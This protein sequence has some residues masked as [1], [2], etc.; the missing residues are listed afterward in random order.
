MPSVNILKEIDVSEY[1]WCNSAVMFRVCNGIGTIT[2]K[3]NKEDENYCYYSHLFLNNKPILQ[4]YEAI[5]PTCSGMLATGYG[6]ENI[7]CPELKAVRECLNSNYTDIK[8]SAEMLKPLLALLD[9]GYYLLADIP[10]FPTDGNNNFFWSVPNDLTE[11]PA[12]CYSYY[13]E[14]F[15]GCTDS[16]PQYLYPTQS[17]ELCN[18]KRIDEYVEILKNNPNSLRALAYHEYGFVSALLDGHHKATAATLLGQKI[19]CLTIIKADGCTFKNVTGCTFKNGTKTP[20]NNNTEINSINFSS[21]RIPV[22]GLYGE[23]FP[24]YN[25]KTDENIDVKKYSLTGR[26]FPKA[27]SN[28]KKYYFDIKTLMEFYSVGIENMEFTDEIIDTWINDTNTD[29]VITYGN[30][31]N[32]ENHI[33]LKC[34][35]KYLMLTNRDMA[36]RTAVKIV[37]KNDNRYFPEV[38]EILTEFKDEQT[39]QLFIDHIVNYGNKSCYYDIVT[40]Y[41]DD[42]TQ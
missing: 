30:A 37:K 4:S 16:F 28:A 14:F 20:Y 35:I 36:Y 29:E 2:H 41:W 18:Q 15:Y 27:E 25:K 9:D 39:E 10:H 38:W 6:I 19:N 12:L 3:T 32:Y 34:A 7:D 31:L 1:T 23:Y 33:R 8:T 42:D 5:C 24:N 11:N 26:K 22:N 21:I 40:S 17:A 13:H